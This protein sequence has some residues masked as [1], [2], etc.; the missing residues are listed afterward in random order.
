[1][2]TG[3]LALR[4]DSLVVTLDPERLEI[5]SV[6]SPLP[7]K[8]QKPGVL[9]ALLSHR[10]IRGK[11]KRLDDGLFTDSVRI[12]ANGERRSLK[13]DIVAHRER[14]FTV[15]EAQE[16]VDEPTLS[17]ERGSIM[18]DLSRLRFSDT[19]EGAC[20]VIAGNVRLLSNWETVAVY[21]IH[22][23]KA[24]TRSFV[25]NAEELEVSAPDWRTLGDV[26]FIAVPD[27]RAAS[28]HKT[29][30]DRSPGGLFSRL[31]PQGTAASL[32]HVGA[33]FVAPIYSR[34][35]LWGAVVAASREPRFISFDA[36]LF[37]SFLVDSLSQSVS[38][39]ESLRDREYLAHSQSLLRNF[40]NDLFRQ[41]APLETLHLHAESLCHHLG[42]SSIFLRFDGES[43]QYGSRLDDSELD[44]VLQTLDRKSGE[45]VELG[46]RTLGESRTGLAI[47][48]SEQVGDF[49]VFFRPVNIFGRTA[50]WLPRHVAFIE[51]VRDALV[52]RFAYLA[53]D[54]EEQRDR[55]NETAHAKND[56]LA[57]VSHELR[58]PL[59]A[60]LGWAHLLRDGD[61]A[62]ARIERAA[63]VILRNGEAQARMVEELLELSRLVNG[64]LRLELGAAN[65]AELVSEVLD[66][67]R[68]SAA[69][70]NVRI[71][72]VVADELGDATIDRNRMSQ[73]LSNLCSNAIR[74]SNGG[75]IVRLEASLDGTHAR[76]V[77][78]DTGHGIDPEFLPHIFERFRQGLTGPK[79]EPGGMGLG[80]SIARDIVRLHGGDLTAQSEG[81]GK[82]ASFEVTIP[83]ENRSEQEGERT[84]PLEGMQIL[85][86]D[87]EA[88]ARELLELSLER[89][90]AQVRTVASAREAL[91][92]LECSSYDAIVSDIGMPEM[93][94]CEMLKTLRARECDLP[95]V[96]VTAFGRPLDRSRTKRAGFSDHFTKPVDVP[97]LVEALRDSTVGR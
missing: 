17:S 86:V 27:V 93:D 43:A 47:P 6:S 56:F 10:R 89:E 54:F 64:Q 75:D 48:L 68:P 60:I 49:L 50:P 73:V 67:H 3:P 18:R 85:V 20:A 74:H 33:Y 28:K 22:A 76:F 65:L 34:D 69:A 2:L 66:V 38:Q 5:V 46:P 71:E 96:A 95:A 14:D 15:L 63:E 16:Q 31:A 88:D 44:V 72:S 42:A 11:L 94:G 19:I 9:D 45:L 13:L 58:T 78:R 79:R 80:L 70:K 41:R 40:A 21:S 8:M 81:F 61:L 97:L 83:L 53:R 90:G 55:L 82:G 7:A 1:M 92:T 91:H 30:L 32:E 51:M 23:E 57:M 26:P 59:N 39:L 52:D 37:T 12:R 35:T 29:T 36:M 4:A 24:V 25:E 84:L 77:V 87:D 62:P